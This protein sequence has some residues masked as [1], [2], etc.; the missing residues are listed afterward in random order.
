MVV[1]D[2]VNGCGYT[3]SNCP[4]HLV[5]TPAIAAISE[6]FFLGTGGIPAIPV[7]DIGDRMVSLFCLRHGD[8]LDLVELRGQPELK[9]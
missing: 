8:G 1:L 9:T 7:L 4:Q 5:M 6:G 3:V 2:G